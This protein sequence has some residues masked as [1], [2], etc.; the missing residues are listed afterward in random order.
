[1][2]M[3]DS[4]GAPISVVEWG[5]L[6]KGK[7][8]RRDF[9]LDVLTGMA[10]FSAE[11]SL[12][13]GLGKHEALARPRWAGGADEEPALAHVERLDV[14]RHPLALAPDALANGEALV[15]A[16][17]GR[18]CVHERESLLRALPHGPDW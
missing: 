8:Q 16:V 18:G 4:T 17:V 12:F 15:T 13:A 1:M 14:E 6:G 10:S 9:R 11:G 3:R 2:T 7:F 5:Y